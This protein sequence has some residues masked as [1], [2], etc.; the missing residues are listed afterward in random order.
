MIALLESY[1]YKQEYKSVVS[2]PFELSGLRTISKNTTHLLQYAT[3]LNQVRNKLIELAKNDPMK[4]HWILI[5]DGNQF[6]TNDAWTKL[7][8]A[9][10]D[11]DR[12]NERYFSV[13]MC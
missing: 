5:F 8:N 7:F 1:G 12:I 13:P 6:I 10:T 4:F 3:N 11:K 2:I 9:G